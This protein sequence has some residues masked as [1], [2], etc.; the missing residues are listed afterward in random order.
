MIADLAF[1]NFD[2][3]R[4]SPGTSDIASTRLC[5][6]GKAESRSST[7]NSMGFEDGFLSMEVFANSREA[8]QIER[9]SCSS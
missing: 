5:G 8:R 1:C 7:V 6:F 9:Q 2:Y 3:P 4:R